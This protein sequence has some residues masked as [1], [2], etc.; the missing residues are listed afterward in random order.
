LESKSIIK[1]LDMRLLSQLKLIWLLPAF[2]T[3]VLA[4][5]KQ[6]FLEKKP[7]STL[8][9]P[10]TLSDFQ[11]LLDNLK[12]FG[13]VP[14][15]GEASADNYYVSY[16]SWQGMTKRE[17]N[18]YVWAKDIY[19][20]EGAQQDWNTPYQQIFYANVVLDGLKGV[21]SIT[22]SAAEW[23]ALEGSALFCR[24]FAFYNLAQLF[25]PVYD[26]GTAKTDPGIPL[27][28]SSS[29]DTL[30]AR[31]TLQA[32]YD[33][34]L[35]DLNQAEAF[36]PGGSAGR[37]LN[38]PVKACAQALLARVYLSMRNYSMAQASADKALVTYPQL[39]DYNDLSLTPVPIST[40]NPETL[41][42][43]S[44]LGAPSLFTYF[45][46]LSALYSTTWIDTGLLRSYDTSDL[47][48]AIFFRTRNHDTTLY[49]RGGY[50]GS[51]YPFGGLATD[52]LLL[53][54]AEGA[55]RAGDAAAAM[56]KVN[57]LLGKRWKKGTF[58]GYPVT[59]APAALDTVLLERR[60]ELA[61]RGLRWTDLRRLNKEGANITLQRILVD[62]SNGQVNSLKFTLAPNSLNYTLPIPPDVIS[63]NAAI[64][65]NSR[66]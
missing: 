31:S 34:I 50:S 20:G 55:A 56:A 49:L 59:T 24:A 43:A 41:Y 66:N 44:F 8:L 23:N 10:T 13:L 37:T 25:A 40:F 3:L 63:L 18:A 64:Q 48:L 9:V 22:D 28:T 47:R 54:S 35:S 7:S 30:S 39:M 5:N 61:F 11:A 36:L 53:I 45:T 2:F 19:G 51:L 42:Q 32:T 6:K 58:S 1:P 65:Q 4:C 14:T 38:R 46:A 16:G 60:K 29:I 26:S 15:L 57:I 33:Q 12:V 27:R 52:E 21:K 62:T 17:M